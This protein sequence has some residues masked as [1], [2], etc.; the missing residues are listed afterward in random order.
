MW[1]CSCC[2]DGGLLLTLYEQL[3]EW[4]KLIRLIS[5]YVALEGERIGLVRQQLQK[6]A[7]TREPE[8]QPRPS[9]MEFSHS[10]FRFV[11]EDIHFHHDHRNFESGVRDNLLFILEIWIFDPG[12][13]K[14]LFWLIFGRSGWS[15]TLKCDVISPPYDYWEASRIEPLAGAEPG[16]G[17][18]E[19]M[20]SLE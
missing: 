8:L 2:L 4:G 3:N 6:K 11:I 19:P 14:L 13:N 7:V 15:R 18:E 16:L 17:A 12:D 20:P 10:E 1:L 5:E 9:A